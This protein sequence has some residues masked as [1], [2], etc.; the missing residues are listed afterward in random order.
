MKRCL[1]L[2]SRNYRCDIDPSFNLVN[3]LELEELVFPTHA[4]DP[5]ILLAARRGEV[6]DLPQYPNS[7]SEGLLNRTLLRVVQIARDLPLDLPWDE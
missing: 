7:A 5:E 6:K 2:Y 4:T 1:F 3:H